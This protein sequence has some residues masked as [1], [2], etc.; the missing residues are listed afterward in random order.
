VFVGVII[1]AEATLT[2]LGAGLQLPAI[3]WGV[4]LSTPPPRA[5]IDTPHLFAFPGLAISLTVFSFVL[6][7]DA[8]RDALDPKLR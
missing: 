5:L 6:L 2:F 1:G 4:L 3:S 8:L 7:G